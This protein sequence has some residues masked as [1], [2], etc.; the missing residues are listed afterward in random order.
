M[1]AAENKLNSQIQISAD[2]ANFLGKIG[3]FR[4]NKCNDHFSAKIAEN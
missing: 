2:F 3:D 4:K 1:L